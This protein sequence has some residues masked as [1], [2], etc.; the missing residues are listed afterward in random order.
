MKIITSNTFAV[1]STEYKYLFV[2]IVTMILL[3]ANITKRNRQLNSTMN[4]WQN[5]KKINMN[6]KKFNYLIKTI[7]IFLNKQL[8][9]NFSNSYSKI[10]VLLKNKIFKKKDFK[11]KRFKK[12]DFKNK[13]FKKKDFK[14]KRFKKKKKIYKFK[15]LPNEKLIKYY[16]NYNL[17]F[18]KYKIDPLGFIIAALT[19]MSYKDPFLTYKVYALVA[20]CFHVPGILYTA[21]NKVYNKVK[22]NG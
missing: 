20:I 17:I 10:M 6:F 1:R 9:L 16:N 5:Y 14:N 19:F 2:I 22:K 7:I 21:Y 12:K 13:R 15:Y 18:I 3:V 11:N 4:F 8:V